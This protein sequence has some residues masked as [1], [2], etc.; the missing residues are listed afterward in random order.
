MRLYVLIGLIVVALVVQFV[1]RP[2]TALEGEGPVH[3]YEPLGK[4]S[5][6][7]GSALTIQ[8]SAAFGCG[9]RED[10]LRALR[11]LTDGDVEAFNSFIAIKAA[12]AGCTVF[13]SGERVFLTDSAIIR[14]LVKVR[15]E[16]GI[17]EYWTATE[18]AR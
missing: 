5:G 15:R 10:Y 17:V 3:Y 4:R 1:T 8:T 11:M 9:D 13:Q 2:R 18:H 12:A 7:S 14:G 6:A 16:G